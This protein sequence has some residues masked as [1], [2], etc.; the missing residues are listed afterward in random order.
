MRKEQ[1]QLRVLHIELKVIIMRI[2]TNSGIS[3]NLKWQG[4]VYAFSY[5][6]NFAL[7]LFI[8]AKIKRIIAIQIPL[9]MM[10]VKLT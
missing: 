3:V 1:K 2:L 7:P 4:I 6:L 5:S 10:L 8:M 9:R